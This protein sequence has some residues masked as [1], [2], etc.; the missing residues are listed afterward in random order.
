MFKKNDFMK[1]AIKEAFKALKKKEVPVGAVIIDDQDKI[2]ARGHNLI[3]TKNNATN[4]AEKI[5]IEK[6][7]KLKKNTL[8]K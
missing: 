4:H 5:V 2:I 7:L 8:F 6:A 3:E 1:Y